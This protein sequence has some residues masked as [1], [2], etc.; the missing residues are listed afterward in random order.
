ML[1]YEKNNKL[2]INFDN[3]VSEQ[4]DLQISKED[5]KTSVT[6]DGYQN[7]SIPVP[8]LPED[9]GKAIIVNEN[10]DYT[11][12]EAG[13]GS[14]GLFVITIDESGETITSDK[15]A[16]EI[17]NAFLSGKTMVAER[18]GESFAPMINIGLGR[19]GVLSVV[20][21]GYYTNFDGSGVGWDVSGI[22]DEATGEIS[23]TVVEI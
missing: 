22:L 13:G 9:V 12:A 7:S 10:G 23:W 11:L 15:T 17:V 4:P 20:D 8:V 19:G 18:W 5:G 21:F 2:N 1:I 3:E 16:E 14:G 6:I